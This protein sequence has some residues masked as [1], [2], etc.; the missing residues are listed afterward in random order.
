VC[1]RH[2][3]LSAFLCLRHFIILKFV[4][5]SL[6]CLCTVCLRHFITPRRHFNV[7]ILCVYVTLLFLNVTL[8]SLYCVSVILLFLNVT[9]LS[10]YCVSTSLYYSSTSLYC[11][12]IVC[13]RHFV[14]PQRHF[15]VSVLC[16]YVTK[17]EKRYS[18]RAPLLASFSNADSMSSCSP[19]MS[20]S[21]GVVCNVASCGRRFE[22]KSNLETHKLEDHKNNTRAP[23]RPKKYNTTPPSEVHDDFPVSAKRSF[24]TF[25]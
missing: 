3:I 17:V 4:S 22:T 1:L 21:C 5:T 9:L 12:C 6:Y 14:I 18:K 2:F 7:S 11:L 13:L 24:D 20:S 15:I 19:G 8:L 23:G 10:L 16:V 25:R